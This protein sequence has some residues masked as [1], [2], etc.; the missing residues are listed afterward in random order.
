MHCSKRLP[1]T[2][3][4]PCNPDAIVI[5]SGFGGAM[6]ARQ[7]VQAGWRVLMLE[8]G[9]WV[10]RGPQNW[11]Q[12]NVGELTGHYSREAAYRQLRGGRDLGAYFYVGGPSV[13]YG[14]L[15]PLPRAG[16]RGGP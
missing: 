13:F 7:L 10:E 16:L 1:P 2:N 11:A 9:G 12:E 6:A 4:G 8:R 5:G 3:L 15:S 14:R